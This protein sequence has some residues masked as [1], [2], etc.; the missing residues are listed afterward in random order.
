ML[1]WQKDLH[2]GM[3]WFLIGVMQLFPVAFLQSQLFGTSMFVISQILG[4]SLQCEMGHSYV[5]SVIIVIIMQ[6]SITTTAAWCKSVSKNV[7]LKRRIH[8][9]HLLD[10]WSLF[11]FWQIA[12]LGWQSQQKEVQYCQ[13][14]DHF[15]WRNRSLCEI[16]HDS[17]ILWGIF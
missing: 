6:L 1:G 13:Q 3:C 2:W 9:R 5:Y 7:L 14:F 4:W 15:A 17:L 10:I 8:K 12:A 16:N 11:Q